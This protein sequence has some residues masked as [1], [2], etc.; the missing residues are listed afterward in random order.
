M[1]IHH[2]PTVEQRRVVDDPLARHLCVDGVELHPAEAPAQT[3]GDEPGS[4]GAGERVQHDGTPWSAREDA[5]L[6]ELRWKRGEV[7]ALVRAGGDGPD[8]ALVAAFGVA[9]RASRI[10]A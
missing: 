1:L 9:W 4:P 8:A 5:R 2:R 3:D 10:G 7:R 6:D